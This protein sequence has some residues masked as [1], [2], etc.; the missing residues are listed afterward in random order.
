[1]QK[2]SYEDAEVNLVKSGEK[3][4]NKIVKNISNPVYFF[5]DLGLA[6]LQNR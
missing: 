6:E 5:M 2:K 3:V 4:F 1:M